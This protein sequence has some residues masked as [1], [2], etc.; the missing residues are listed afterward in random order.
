MK[1][2]LI[3]DDLFALKLLSRQLT[4]LGY[5]EVIHCQ[6][7]QDALC[8]LENDAGSISLVI[9]DLCMPSMD[10]VEFL[11][12]MARIGYTGCLVLVSGESPRILQTAEKLARAHRLNVLGA[13]SKPVSQDRWRQLLQGNFPSAGSAAAAAARDYGLEEVKSAIRGNELVNH[14]QPKVALVDGGVV[15]VETL[16]RWQHPR[17]GLV[18]P[19]RFIAVAEQ[20]GLIGELTQTVLAAALRQLRAWRDDGFTLKVAIN[21]SMDSLSALEFPDWVADQVHAAG[22][23]ADSLILEVTESQLMVDKVASLDTLT[24]LRLKQ[25]GLSIDDFGT[26][27]SSLSQLRDIPFNELKIDRSFVYGVSRDG[28]LRAIVEASLE[29]ARQLGMI[30]VAEGVEEQADWD[31]L[32]ASGCDQAQGYLIAKPMPAEKLS[33]WLDDWRYKRG[34]L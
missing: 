14:Y 28:S 13:V 32:R 17:D 31:L 27:H 8:K 23:P 33:G 6:Q 20:H 9:C 26:G 22:V 30:T 3:D 5:R 4:T 24:R 2:L 25:V 10:G 18:F 7:A 15:G 12:H 21:V 16:V 11:R 34:R 19:D 1:I 29:M